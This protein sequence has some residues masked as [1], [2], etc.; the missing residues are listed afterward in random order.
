M[1]S[2]PLE[3]E[4]AYK[5]NIGGNHVEWDISVMSYKYYTGNP[6]N[7]HKRRLLLLIQINANFGVAWA[8]SNGLQWHSI[9]GTYVGPEL[10]YQQYRGWVI[11][12]QYIYKFLPSKEYGCHDQDI[13]GFVEARDNLLAARYMISNAKATSVEICKHKASNGDGSVK[14]DGKMEVWDSLKIV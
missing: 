5:I 14:E 10:Y 9:Q 11:G 1:T 8:F 13:R 4:L 2:I 7:W 6:K 3:D 12:R